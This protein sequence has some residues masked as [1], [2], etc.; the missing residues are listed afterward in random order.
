[1]TAGA[2]IGCGTISVV[3]LGAITSLDGVDLV[4]VCDT[5]ADRAAEVGEKYGVPWFTDHARVARDGA[6]PGR[7]RLH[8]AQRARPGGD[9]QPG[10]RRR[11][12]AGEARRPHRRRGRTAPRRQPGTPR[13]QDRGVPPES[14][15]RERAGGQGAARHGR[16]GTG[17]R[18][19]RD[20]ALAP[21]SRVLRSPAMARAEARQRRRR[22]HQP[23]DPHPGPA[24]V[25]ARGRRRRARA[26]RPVRAGRRRRRRGHGVRRARSRRRRPERA[27]RDRHQRH[28]HA[29]DP[30][31]R[32]GAGRAAASAATSP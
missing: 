24:P 13:R 21:R 32:H 28:R 29:R 10:R 25:A 12:P 23:G 4:G 8:P 2:V 5:D 1:M 17:P 19:V 16:A 31:D 15:Q 20:P 22:P 3:H 9:R 14:L 26:H 30:R 27:L 18:R 11:R 6:P 7:A